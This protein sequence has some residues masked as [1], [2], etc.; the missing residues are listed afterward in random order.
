MEKTHIILQPDCPLVSI[1]ENK[2]IRGFK[3]KGQYFDVFL[4]GFV[5]LIS[6][7]NIFESNNIIFT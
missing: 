1:S 4:T 3:F 7:I 5:G 6:T 2:M